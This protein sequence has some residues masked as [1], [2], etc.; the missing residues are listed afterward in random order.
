MKPFLSTFALIL[1]AAIL[2]GCNSSSKPS[3]NFS[4]PFWAAS[5]EQSTAT[6]NHS[7]WNQL[8]GKYVV[9]N[10]P[11]KINRFR[12]GDVSRTDKKSLDKYIAQLAAADPRLYR[13]PEQK[14]YWINLYNALVVQQILSH[15]PIASVDQI[16][17]M[18]L[19]STLVTIQGKSLS[20]N[21]IEHRILR[22][23]WRDHRVHFAL[24]D[25]SL[26]APNLQPV[27][28]TGRTVRA[29]LKQ[30]GR[31]YLNHPRALQVEKGKMRAARLFSDH[32]GDFATNQ[33]GLLKL[34]AHY[35]DDRKA[36]YLLGFQGDIEYHQDLALNAP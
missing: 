12:Y 31:E 15:Y 32:S 36:L 24:V 3:G 30:A 23:L 9:A 20:L 5:N 2:V 27:A 8:L 28:Y 10:H 22:P 14:A 25:G 33:A 19:D 21:D 6:I 29:M 18:S 17:E 34:F 35:V 1:T 13:K 4:Q 26:G 11:S 7:R 16:G